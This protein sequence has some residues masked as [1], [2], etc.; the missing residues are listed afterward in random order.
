MR[1]SIQQASRSAAEKTK[2]QEDPEG[3]DAASTCQGKQR[4]ENSKVQRKQR[5]RRVRKTTGDHEQNRTEPEQPAKQQQLQQH[6]PV[7]GFT[8]SSW[9]SLF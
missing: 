7:A 8:V 1:F 2:T 4:D 6:Q 3:S 9:L 5:V